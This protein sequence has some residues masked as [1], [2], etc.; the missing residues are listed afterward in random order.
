MPQNFTWTVTF[1]GIG[2]SEQAGLALFGPSPSVGQNYSDAW[3]G[4]AG[5]SPTWA[6]DVASGSNPALTFGATVTAV[7]EPSSL[8][9][10][11]M[12]G[13]GLLAS[14]WRKLRR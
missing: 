9:L 10:F 2:A 7:P 8:G 14:G 1:A 12:G 3:Y 5:T 13:F 4:A 6:L 11:A